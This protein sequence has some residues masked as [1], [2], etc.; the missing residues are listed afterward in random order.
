MFA[1][2]ARL[3]TVALLPRP[4]KAERVN[5]SRLPRSPG[6]AK[7]LIVS[8]WARVPGLVGAKMSS[9]PSL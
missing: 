2:P 8:A 4:A 6:P 1:P 9:E 5:S 7:P 3:N